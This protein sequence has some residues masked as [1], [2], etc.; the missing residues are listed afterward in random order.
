MKWLVPLALALVGCGPLDL[1]SQP[2]LS[3]DTC[4][5]VHMTGTLAF[6]A[7]QVDVTYQLNGAFIARRLAPTRLTQGAAPTALPAAFG[8]LYPNGASVTGGGRIV[9]LATRGGQPVGYGV[10][11]LSSMSSV[12]AGEHVQ[13]TLEMGAASNH[14]F[15]GVEGTNEADVDCGGNDCPLCGPGKKCEAISNGDFTCA[16]GVCVNAPNGAQDHCR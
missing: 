3:R 6:E 7:L 13:I 10:K 11:Q 1:C 12:K 8:L 16:S 14:C 2:E 9:V 15:D 5:T 4:L